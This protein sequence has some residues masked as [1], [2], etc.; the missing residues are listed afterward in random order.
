MD[1]RLAIVIISIGCVHNSVIRQEG[2]Q[3]KSLYTSDDKV[4]V[5]THENFYQSVYDQAY[6]SN[7]EFY[8]SFCGFCRNF[9]PI[10]KQ[11]A[12]DV[13]G[14]RDI[15]RVSAIDCA[16]DANNDICRDMEIMRY[17][18][19]RYFPPYYRNES[20]HF[21]VEV[22]HAAMTVG[23]PFLL[24][25]MA[26]T[27]ESLNSWPK[28]HP[29]NVSSASAL[30]NESPSQIEYIF[31]IY[32]GKNDSS[33]T[34]KVALDLHKVK[35]AQIRHIASTSVAIKLG[36]KVQSAIF[37]GIKSAMTI[38]LV[39]HLKVLDRDIIRQMIRNYLTSK[40]IRV[41]TENVD[42]IASTKEIA[43]IDEKSLV[44]L[45]YVKAHPDVV[46]QSDLESAIRFS[47]FHELVKYNVMNDEQRTA[48]L[49]YLAVLNK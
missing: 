13:Y 34:Q 41:T 39:E 48:I 11:F 33:V 31:M 32:D 37:V 29:V 30:F 40:G 38:Q 9:A 28:L 15:V 19:L 14:W 20:G 1:F 6:A 23:E 43:P 44:I 10:Y 42:V 3:A 17:P 18:T 26:N 5:L 24:E 16:A 7:V 25:L 22:Q 21:G 49:R 2:E 46:F 45:D 36:L 35:Q 47:I 4:F 27:S 8:N 12:E